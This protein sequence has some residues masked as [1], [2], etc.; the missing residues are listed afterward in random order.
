MPVEIK[1]LIVRAVQTKGAKTENI[2]Q[3]PDIEA[4]IQ[5]CVDK[6]LKVLNKK[7]RR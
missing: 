7:S 1:E 4:V 3:P 5:S 2:Q 6:T